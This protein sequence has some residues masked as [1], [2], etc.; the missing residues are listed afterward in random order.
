MF[1]L[2]PLILEEKNENFESKGGKGS[3][4]SSCLQTALESLSP[5]D[6]ICV[7]FQEELESCTFSS[8]DRQQVPRRAG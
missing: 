3:S 6:P 1:I 4:T 5:L 7:I 8:L 2:A